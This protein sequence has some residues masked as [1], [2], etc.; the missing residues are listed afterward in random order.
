L[1]HCDTAPDHTSYPFST[2]NVKDYY[3]LLSVYLDATFFPKLQQYD[4]MQEG[5]RLEFEKLDGASPPLHLSGVFRMQ[6]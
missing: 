1:R 4:F 2:Q 5:H 3:N 6:R